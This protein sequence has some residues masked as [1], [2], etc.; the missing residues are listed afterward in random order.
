MEVHPSS[1]HTTTLAP[2][3]EQTKE[4][5]ESGE[6][7]N[8]DENLADK[9]RSGTTLEMVS[10][11]M[12]FND[13]KCVV[14]TPRKR[15]FL[16]LGCFLYCIDVLSDIYVAI[17][18]FVTSNNDTSQL[19]LASVMLF[20]VLMPLAYGNYVAQKRRYNICSF[21]GSNI[22]RKTVWYVDP[23]TLR[24]RPFKTNIM[25]LRVGFERTHCFK[26][27][28]YVT[29]GGGNQQFGDITS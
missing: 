24:G 12:D 7:R 9:A 28:V 11:M 5:L 22:T 3:D 19:I 15:F 16:G 8:E 21:F 29:N 6:L 20:F 23:D 25:S 18:T 26:S 1:E 4:L 14:F 10:S 13:H 27:S 2:S 17:S